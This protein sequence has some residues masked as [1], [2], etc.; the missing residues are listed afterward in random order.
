[1]RVIRVS[2]SFFFKFFKNVIF[3][4]SKAFKQF[5]KNLE[6]IKI[7]PVRKIRHI[8]ER[9]QLLI[10]LIY[11]NKKNFNGFMIVLTNDGDIIH[12]SDNINYYLQL[13]PVSLLIHLVYSSH[14][15]N[16]AL[17]DEIIIANGKIF[18]LIGKD[19]GQKIR[20]ILSDKTPRKVEPF[21]VNW[22]A[23]KRKSVIKDYKVY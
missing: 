4:V 2:Y 3:F 23:Y 20:Q 14:D 10:L 7:S 1:M 5:H 22:Q 9:P 19:D 11:F 15:F 13:T 8:D 16:C 21:F 6:N 17:K 12:I 18:S